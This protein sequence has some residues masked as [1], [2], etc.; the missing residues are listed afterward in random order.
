MLIA[1]LI[2]TIMNG[3]WSIMV[4]VTLFNRIEQAEH[5]VIKNTDETAKDM[6]QYIYNMDE[7]KKQAEAACG[8]GV[9]YET[10][11]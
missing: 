2:L 4:Y 7:M 5:K 9:T 11:D 8:Y 10:Q 3:L 6:L 1:I